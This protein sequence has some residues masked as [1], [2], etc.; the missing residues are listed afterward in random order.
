MSSVE[1]KENADQSL[2]SSDESEDKGKRAF[3]KKKNTND[4]SKKRAWKKKA[5]YFFVTGVLVLAGF[6]AYLLLDNR[7]EIEWIPKLK[8]FPIQNSKCIKLEPFI[9]PF[10]EHGKFT[11]I[12]L[13]ISFELPNKEMRDEM[14]EKNDWIRGIIYDILEKNIYVLE[15][16]SSLMKLKKVIIDNVNKVLTTGEVNKTIITDFFTV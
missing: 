2:D 11:Y 7:Q 8:W 16:V 4:Q 1:N 6:S 9:I 5:F 14:M 15:N 3:F 10:K 13:S 12:S